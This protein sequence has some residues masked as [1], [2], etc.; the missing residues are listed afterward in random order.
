[1]TAIVPDFHKVRGRYCKTQM[2]AALN[3]Q[4]EE[5]H[6]GTGLVAGADVDD[7]GAVGVAGG[8]EGDDER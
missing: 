7:R 4:K 2:L 1:M 3:K 5:G 6:G 8:D